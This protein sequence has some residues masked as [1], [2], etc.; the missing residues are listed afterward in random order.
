MQIE[1]R[2]VGV[3]DELRDPPAF[4][5]VVPQLNGRQVA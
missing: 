4:A 2:L 3:D 5:A 1:Q